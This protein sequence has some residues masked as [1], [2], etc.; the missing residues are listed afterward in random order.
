MTI[1]C[2]FYYNVKLLHYPRLADNEG[3]D[4][5]FINDDLKNEVP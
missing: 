4:R 2:F 1:Y 3:K 5:L